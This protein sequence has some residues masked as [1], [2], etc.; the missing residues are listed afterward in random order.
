MQAFG[1]ADQRVDNQI[2]ADTP[3]RLGHCTVGA[4]LA[5]DTGCRGELDNPDYH[6]VV[7]VDRC[8]AAGSCKSTVD[9]Q[10]HIVGLEGMDG[11]GT[12]R[13]G[14]VVG[15]PGVAALAQGVADAPLLV[16]HKSPGYCHTA[17]A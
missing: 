1:T 13:W 8:R 3:E 15:M 11:I 9:L 10:D 17:G 5:E 2:V 7:Q 4:R 14:P 6:T 12:V 16:G